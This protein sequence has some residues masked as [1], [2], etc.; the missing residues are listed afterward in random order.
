MVKSLDG[1]ATG[2]TSE[3]RH[4]RIFF[5][6]VAEAIAQGDLIAIAELMV[7][8]SGGK[9]QASG[10]GEQA[11]VTFQLIYQEGVPGNLTRTRTSRLADGENIAVNSCTNGSWNRRRGGKT[12]DITGMGI[13]RIDDGLLACAGSQRSRVA[14]QGHSVLRV[15]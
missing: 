2:E 10:V 6:I 13:E 11:A 5:A 3:R 4:I 12:R 7:E 9:V 8:A 14:E 1:T 15:R